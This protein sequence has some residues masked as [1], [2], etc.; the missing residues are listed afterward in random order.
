[1]TNAPELRDVADRASRGEAP[2]G[3]TVPPSE[4][5]EARREGRQGVGAPHSTAEAGEPTRGTRWREG[6]AGRMDL[7]EGKMTGTLRPEPIS[8]R[9]QQ[10]AELARRSPQMCFTSLNH[11][12]DLE[13]MQEAYRRTRKDGAAGVDGQSSAE[14]SEALETN[15]EGLLDRAKTG[16]YRAPAV[17]RVHIPK[18][19]GGETRPIGI[20]TFEDKVLQRAVAM[21]LEAIYEQDFLESSYGFRP[22]R[23]AHQALEVL[24]RELFHAGGGWVIDVDIR[25][26]FDTL[27]HGHL[28]A[29]VGQRVRDG[30]VTRLIGKWLNAGVMEEGSVSYPEAGSPQG[31]VISPLLSNIYLHEVV[32][33]WF[34]GEVKPRLR[35]R[36]WLVRYADDL[37]IAVTDEADVERV[38]KVL[39]KRLGK[40]GLALH[41]EKTRVV[42]FRRPSEREPGRQPA[43]FDF[44]GFTHHWARSRRGRWVVKRKTAQKRFTRALKAVSQWCR[45]NLHRP[46]AE[47]QQALARKLTGHYNY[48]GITGN[49]N[50]LSRFRYRVKILWKKWL[51]RRSQRAKRSWDWF[52][53]L[54]ERYPLPPAR[55]VHSTYRPVAKPFS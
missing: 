8:T 40:Y 48:Y 15:L 39:P 7:L 22:G 6:E 52:N 23:S 32:D 49:S 2:A 36:G 43:T 13:W 10:I 26:F 41:P 30:V 19:D 33:R 5:N 46:L 12:L 42:D 54:V 47:Q 21:L 18:G 9:V 11:H 4:G 27:D 16:S 55:A 24:Q 44:L 50:A 3:G 14:Y 17:R 31:G 51:M 29:I 45:A 34:E 53:R 37:V 1:M 35:G 28:Q 20:P 38:M 25:K